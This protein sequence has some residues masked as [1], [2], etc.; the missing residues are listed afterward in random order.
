ML[1]DP[2]GDA[3]VAQV[4]ELTILEITSRILPQ[5]P[6]QMKLPFAE[7]GTTLKGTRVFCFVWGPEEGRTFENR[8]GSGVI[9]CEEKQKERER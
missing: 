2:A 5:I 4:S 9:H 8:E 7:A 6:G 1:T 3:H